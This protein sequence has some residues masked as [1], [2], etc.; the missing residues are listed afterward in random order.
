MELTTEKR[1]TDALPKAEEA[2]VDARKASPV[3]FCRLFLAIH[4]SLEHDVKFNLTH[5]IL[6]QV[7][8][9][10]KNYSPAVSKNE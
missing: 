9:F 8:I 5:L 7:N 1:E 6:K 2:A 10:N 3:H 4:L